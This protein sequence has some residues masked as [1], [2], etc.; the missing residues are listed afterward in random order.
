MAQKAAKAADI[1]DF[2][3]FGGLFCLGY[4][5]YL[6]KPWAGWAV[7]GVASMALGLGW[8]I[9]RSDK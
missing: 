8:L 3:V 9:R 2:L 7:F 4:G 6:L 1:R 5:F